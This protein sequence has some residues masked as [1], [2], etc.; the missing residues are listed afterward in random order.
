MSPYFKFIALPVFIVGFML[1]ALSCHA[2]G[3]LVIGDSISAQLDSW[4]SFVR[5]QTGKNVMVMAQ[6]GRTARD[7]TLPADLRADG[8]IDTAVYFL[9]TNDALQK[10]KPAL[11]QERVLTQLRFLKDR[12]FRV[13]VVL[14]PEFVNR[15]TDVRKINNVLIKQATNLKLETVSLAPIW[16]TSLTSDTIH[17]TPALSREIAYAVMEIL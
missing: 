11:Y 17:P 15:E 2:K 10:T 6:N 13:I 1:M 16:D 14:I 12:G 4:P 5:E 9:G 7:F 8:N 3:T